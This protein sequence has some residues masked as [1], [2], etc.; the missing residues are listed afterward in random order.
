MERPDGWTQALNLHGQ[1]GFVPTAY[2]QELTAEEAEALPLAPASRITLR[3][4]AAEQPLGMS[5][6][7]GGPVY[8]DDV[9]VERVQRERA[10]V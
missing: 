8:I 5:L 4:A 7:G 1:V 2:V 3:R 9:R 10:C 6:A